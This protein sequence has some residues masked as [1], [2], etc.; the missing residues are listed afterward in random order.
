MVLVRRNDLHMEEKMKCGDCCVAPNGACMC[1]GL[2][3]SSVLQAKI[4]RLGNLLNL[5]LFP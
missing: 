1:Q 4:K 5:Q 3:V 2:R